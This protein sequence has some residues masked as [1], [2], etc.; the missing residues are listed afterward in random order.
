MLLELKSIFSSVTV[1]EVHMQ[2]P[3]VFF[4]VSNKQLEK[5]KI[6]GD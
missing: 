2:K 4:Q 3:I 6:I 1:Y 5:Y